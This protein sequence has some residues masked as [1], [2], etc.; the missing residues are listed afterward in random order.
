M[1]KASDAARSV[2]SAFRRFRTARIGVIKG[3]RKV[4][5]DVMSAELIMPYM[6]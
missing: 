4:Y 2:P 3:Q 6:Q 1:K 5:L